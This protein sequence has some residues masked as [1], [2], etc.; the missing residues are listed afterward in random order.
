MPCSL[1]YCYA[2]LLRDVKDLDKAFPDDP[3]VHAFVEALAPQLA[4]AIT[5]LRHHETAIPCA[6]RT[7][8]FEGSCWH[9]V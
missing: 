3:E 8:A 2:H 7:C 6:H 1:Q 5:H 9:Y 4:S